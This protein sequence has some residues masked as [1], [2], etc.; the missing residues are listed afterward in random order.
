[1]YLPYAAILFQDKD[2]EDIADKQRRDM[3]VKSHK[4]AKTMLECAAE[5]IDEVC[6]LQK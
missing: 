3:V 4:I 2:G 6:T 1:M 5:C